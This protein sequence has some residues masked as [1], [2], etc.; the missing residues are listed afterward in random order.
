MRENMDIA[1]RIFAEKPIGSA[2]TRLTEELKKVGFGIMTR[3]SVKE[4]L[5]EKGIDFGYEIVLLGVCKPDTAKKALETNDAIA[6]MLPCSIVLYERGDRTEIALAEPTA[7]SSFFEGEGLRELAA[8]VES[9]L[10]KAID[11]V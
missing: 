1:Y 6:L 11:A 4:K 3:V 10:K 7:I 8:T 5:A 9:A 2:E